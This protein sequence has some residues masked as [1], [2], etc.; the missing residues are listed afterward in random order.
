MSLDQMTENAPLPESELPEILAPDFEGVRDLKM[1]KAEL[2]YAQG[3][4]IGM[5]ENVEK[6]KG[7]NEELEKDLDFM[8]NRN[9]KLCEHIGH[10]IWLEAAYNREQAHKGT[11]WFLLLML[12]GVLGWASAFIV[13]RLLGWP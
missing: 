10:L 4:T 8:R 11:D 1:L 12:G 3:L 7:Q 5:K 2:A 6:L 9:H 13:A